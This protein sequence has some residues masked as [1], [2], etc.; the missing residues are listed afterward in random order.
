MRRSDWRLE[1]Q[2]HKY[3][4][5]IKVDAD[6]VQALIHDLNVSEEDLAVL[7]VK[8]KEVKY[9]ANTEASPAPADGA[10]SIT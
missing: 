1:T 3:R 9:L 2:R 4:P 6:E 10:R 8:L 5:A 7:S